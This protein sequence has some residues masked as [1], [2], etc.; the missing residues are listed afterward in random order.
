MDGDMEKKI[1][2]DLFLLQIKISS[3]NVLYYIYILILSGKVA[4]NME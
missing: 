4:T 2:F 1:K 3:H